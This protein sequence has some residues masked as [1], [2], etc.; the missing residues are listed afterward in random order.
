MLVPLLG[1]R[2]GVGPVTS[3]YIVRDLPEPIQGTGWGLLRSVF[4]GLGAT[5]ST[6]IGVFADAGL[7]NTGFLVLAGLTALIGPCWMLI[8]SRSRPES[9]EKVGRRQAA[10]VRIY[11]PSFDADTSLYRPEPRNLIAGLTSPHRLS[12]V[13]ERD[14]AEATDEV[15][16]RDDGYHYGQGSV[17]DVRT[18]KH[19][20]EDV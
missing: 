11:P 6:V 2:I 16:G 14:K 15:A 18:V 9:S 17:A 4:F 1:V 7:F 12:D 8:P 19:P 3:A 5:G 13:G 10:T 20:E